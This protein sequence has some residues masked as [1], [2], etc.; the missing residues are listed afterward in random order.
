MTRSA[1]AA[2]RRPTPPA[3]LSAPV[4]AWWRS[5]Q[6]AYEIE[7]VGGLTL[8]GLAAEARERMSRAA[9][10]IAEHGEVLFPPGL[11]PRANPACA[12]ERD[13]RSQMLQALRAL[14]LDVEPLRDAPGRPSGK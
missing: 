1:P 5:M 4:L 14:N 2:E 6:R 12:V 3:N 8:L 11:A 13:A 7:D 10:I 9:G